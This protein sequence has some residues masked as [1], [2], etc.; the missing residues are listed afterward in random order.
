[1]RSISRV[2]GVSINIVT[3]LLVEALVRLARRTTMRRC[4]TNV[5]STLVE[6][7]E[8]WPFVYAKDKNVTTAAAPDGVGDVWTWTAIDAEQNDPVL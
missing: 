3:K 2:A 1:M 4:A 6:C 7:D 5:G 8:I